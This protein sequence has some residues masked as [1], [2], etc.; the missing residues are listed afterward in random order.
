MELN[1]QPLV[2]VIIISYNH[3]KYI[4]QCL[5]GVF[6]QTYTNIELII[7]DDASKDNTQ[8]IIKNYLLKKKPFLLK[9]CLN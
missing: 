5:E 6:S 4:E 9:H 7:R 2:S 8:Q 3:E 1:E